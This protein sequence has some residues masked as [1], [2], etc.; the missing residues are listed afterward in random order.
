MGKEIKITIPDIMFLW[1]QKEAE[2]EDKTLSAMGRKCIKTYMGQRF[3]KEAI[4]RPPED[5]TE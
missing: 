3:G 2:S 5:I 4:K 1:F